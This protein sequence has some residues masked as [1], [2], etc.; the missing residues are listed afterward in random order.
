MKKY[1]LI[2]KKKINT[3]E[4]EIL[5]LPELTKKLSSLHEK[6]ILK[7]GN[8]KDEYEEQILSV[9][10][11]KPNNCVLELGGNIG[12]NSMIIS[13]LLDDPKKLVVIEPSKNIYNQLIENKN[14]NNL[15]FNSECCAI[16]ER[17]LWSSKWNT[18]T[19]YKPGTVEID[20]MSFEEVKN[21]YNYR[22]DTL[23]CD[24]EGA[25]YYILQDNEKILH[26][27]E[28]IIIENDFTDIKHKE[29]VDNIFKKYNL[30]CV[31][32]K[33]GDSYVKTYLP[34]KQNFYEVWKRHV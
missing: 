34:C 25:L 33:E 24:C 18:Y 23:V 21:K 11:I 16:S 26:D 29:Y 4:K 27:I 12:R 5:D 15:L 3:K 10:Y 17:K 32:Q 2:I 14:N 13:L 8:W 30:S 22:F 9:N 31:Y 6:L 20:T 28:T 7:Y 19:E 1:I